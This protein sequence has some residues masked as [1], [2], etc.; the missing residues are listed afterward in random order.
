MM[1]EVLRVQAAVDDGRVLIWESHPDHPGG[2]A[3]VTGDGRVVEVVR[4]TRV[5][6]LIE[7]GR[8]LVIEDMPPASDPEPLDGY[9]GMTAA[10][11][12]GL[13]DE[14]TPQEKAV[15]LEYEAA[16]KARKTILEA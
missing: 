2:E 14:M 8:L 10:E 3:F 4:T 6:A 13:L 16:H 9:D 15:I 1:A 7:Q 11:I 5:N 12:I